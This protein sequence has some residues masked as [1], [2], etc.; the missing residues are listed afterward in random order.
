ME[1]TELEKLI[2]EILE[3]EK[4][5]KNE[6]ESKEREKKSKAEKEYSKEELEIRKREIQLQAEKQ[7]Q[8]QC[9]IVF[10]HSRS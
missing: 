4:N 6:L 5:A 10:F 9:S 7:D 3:R 8:T 1:Q 2:E